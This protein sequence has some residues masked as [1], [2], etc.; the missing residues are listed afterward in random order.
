MTSSPDLSKPER[1][2][3]LSSLRFVAAILV[4]L[5]HFHYTF[6]PANIW[7]PFEDFSPMVSFFFMLSGFLLAHAYGPMNLAQSGRFIALRLARIWPMHLLMLGATWWLLPIIRDQTM[8][9]KEANTI[10]WANIFLLQAWMP[11]QDYFFSFNVVTWYLSTL[12]A[13]YLVFPLLIRNFTN[14]WRIKLLIGAALLLGAFLLSDGK[15]LY[16]PHVVSGQGWLYISVLSRLFEFIVG[17]CASLGYRWLKP[18]YPQG[19]KKLGTGIEALVL[20]LVIAAMAASPL[21]SKIFAPIPL[22]GPALNYY[23]SFA[24]ATLLPFFLLLT[25]FAMERGLITR[26]LAHPLPVLLGELSFGIY[27]IH[28]TLIHVWLYPVALKPHAPIPTPE[29]IALFFI[30]LL[31]LSYLSWR[32]VEKPVAALVSRLLPATK[33][34]PLTK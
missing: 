31:L 34:S 27:I 17:M 4:V 18:Q 14:T 6:W 15:P 1:F 26:I 7:G 24:G 12:L 30:I 29:K 21:I 9:L 23:L 28:V 3:A 19:R 25:V 13:C 16:S 11:V 5:A 20:A 8:H 10:L 33:D 22:C 32:C 2:R